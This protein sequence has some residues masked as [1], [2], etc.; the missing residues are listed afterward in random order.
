MSNYYIVIGGS[1]EG[2]FSIE[3][4]KNKKISK[5]TLIWNETMEDWTEASKIDELSDLI[6]KTPPPIPKE[7]N[8][9]LKVEAEISKKKEKLI[10]PETEVIT[11]KEIK[12]NIKMIFF[13]LIIGLVSYPVYYVIDDGFAHQ[14]MYNKWK[15]YFAR[16]SFDYDNATEEAKEKEQERWETLR[17]ESRR[18]G[19]RESNSYGYSS[20]SLA[21]NFHEDQ[22][23]DAAKNAIKPPI[24]TA[25]IASIVL[26]FGRYLII[27]VKWVDD[28]SKKQV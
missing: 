17:R 16:P 19:W 5:S 2:P 25:I 1:Q 21:Y 20:Y 24:I 3:E 8:K 22:Y 4:L 13:A 10:K 7:P 27:G 12:T 18:L 28:T 23:K 15:Q 9:P 11:A 6:G 26:I 14:N